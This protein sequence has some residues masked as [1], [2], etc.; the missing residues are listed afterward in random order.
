MSKTHKFDNKELIVIF[1]EVLAAMEVKEFNYFRIRAYQNVIAV[2]EGLTV[3]VFN[4]WENNR[5]AE[6]PG[7]GETIKGAL[8]ELFTT[9]KVTEFEA[10]KHDLPQGMFELIGIRGIGA[11]KA[12]KLAKA[13]R[14]KSREEAFVRIKKAAKEEKIRELDG[15]GEKSEK[16]ILEAVSNHKKTKKEKE[17][18]LLVKAEV[19][20][21]RVIS[22]LKMHPEISDAIV[23][24]SYR[25]RAPTVGDLDIAIQTTNP[26]VAIK[27]YEKYEEVEEIL[28]SGDKRASAVLANDFQVDIRI[29]EEKYFGSMLQYF[30]GSKAHNIVLRTHALEK[31]CSLSEYGIKKKK[32]LNEFATEEEFYEFLGLS[33]VP[34]EI[35]QGKNEVQLAAKKKIP[36]LIEL[37]DI[38]GELHTHTIASGDGVNTLKEMVEAATNKGYEY[39]G[40]SDH[41]PSIQS[42]GY[43][44][45]AEIIK[46][47]KET[48]NKLNK[49]QDK[50]KVFYGYEVNILADATI[51]LPDELLK[52]LD[53]AIGGVHGAFN[54]DREKMTKR[55][56]A[57]CENPYINIIAHPAGRLIN[58]RESCDIEWS[59]VFAAAKE[60]GTIIEI[61]AHPNRLDL[62]EDLVP[63]AVGLGINLMINTDAHATDQLNYMKYGID[64]ARRGW[65]EAKDIANTKD[66]EA[67]LLTLDK[68]SL[69]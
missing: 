51:S 64:V 50:I 62:A 52:E 45:V 55:L 16:L 4:L 18:T 60:N 38:K 17:R 23:L 25:R 44:E 14:I 32:E 27:H 8:D 58:E 24:G 54:Q 22:Y 40:I 68:S 41:A 21:D 13:F 67:F 12:Y 7:V 42:R 53:Y 35:R 9:G 1:K 47:A 48:I 33:W 56:I 28:V 46:N 49:A 63:R 10:I 66:L 3:S 30:T 39:I 2:I 26:E 5:L 57:A 59:K 65:C 61:N 36:K 29:C 43:D 11:K 15:F 69:R 34:P 19:I 31:G 37:G 20:A 6:I